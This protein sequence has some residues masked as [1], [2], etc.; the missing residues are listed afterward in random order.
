LASRLRAPFCTA[1]R[2][3]GAGGTSEAG[4]TATTT[5]RFDSSSASPCLPDWCSLPSSMC[6]LESGRQAPTIPFSS[7]TQRRSRLAYII[8]HLRCLVNGRGCGQK[9]PAGRGGVFEDQ[10]KRGAFGRGVH[11][12]F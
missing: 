7:W 3:S 10:A 5:S 9:G 12:L 1:S 2:S 6:R 4:S 8:S 11:E